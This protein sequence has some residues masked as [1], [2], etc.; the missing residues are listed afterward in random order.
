MLTPECPKLAS[1]GYNRAHNHLD[2]HMDASF[3]NG[4]DSLRL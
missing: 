2:P 3:F 4:G 1:K